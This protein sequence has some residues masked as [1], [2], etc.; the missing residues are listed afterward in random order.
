MANVNIKPDYFGIQTEP[1]TVYFAWT[2]RLPDPTVF[3]EANVSVTNGTLSNF[4][5]IRRIHDLTT[6]QATITPPTTGSGNTV[7]TVAANVYDANEAVT[8]NLP[9]AQTATNT[10]KLY[11][12]PSGD[13]SGP[14]WVFVIIFISPANLRALLSLSNFALISYLPNFTQEDVSIDVGE[15]SDYTGVI[16]PEGSSFGDASVKFKVT[17][18]AGAGNLT[19]TVRANAIGDSPETT[20]TIAYSETDVNV[21]TQEA[22]LPATPPS[23]AID[24]KGIDNSRA[25][26]FTVTNNYFYY[27]AGSFFNGGASLPM[28]R[29]QI[30]RINRAT[31][32]EEVFDISLVSGLFITSRI[33][34][35][36]NI[37]ETIYILTTF[38]ADGAGNAVVRRLAFNTST[39]IA[40]PTTIFTTADFASQENRS[41]ARW[42]GLF[43]DGSQFV[44]HLYDS[45]TTRTASSLGFFIRYTT[46]TSTSPKA[47]TTYGDVDAVAGVLGFAFLNNTLYYRPEYNAFKYTAPN[48]LYVETLPLPGIGTSDGNVGTTF[49]SDNFGGGFTITCLAVH[50]NI[51][52]G[53]DTQNYVYSINTTTGDATRLNFNS[54]IAVVDDVVGLA[55]TNNNVYLPVIKTISNIDHSFL[56]R[57]NRALAF[58]QVKFLSET[59]IR[60]I[61]VFNA[62]PFIIYKQGSTTYLGRWADADATPQVLATISD[63]DRFLLCYNNLLFVTDLNATTFRCY[64]INGTRLSQ[65]DFSLTHRDTLGTVK[66][67]SSNDLGINITHRL[68]NATFISRYNTS[69]LFIDSQAVVTNPLSLLMK[70]T[71]LHNDIFYV[72]NEKPIISGSIF[73]FAIHQVSFADGIQYNGP[74]KITVNNFESFDLKPLFSGETALHEGIG[75]LLDVDYTFVNGVLTLQYVLGQVPIFNVTEIFFPIVAVNATTFLEQEIY[76]SLKENLDLP[77]WNGATSIISEQ[78]DQIDLHEF[79]ENAITINFKSGSTI[80]P[81]VSI[82]NNTL[83]IS[84]NTV[85][86]DS[87]FEIILTAS[88][89][90]GS[91]DKELDLLI[92]NTHTNLKIASFWQKDIIEKVY[93]ADIDV[94]EH[95]ESVSDIDLSLD[96]QFLNVQKVSDATI[97]LNDPDGYFSSASYSNFFAQNGLNRFGFNVPIKIEYG[98]QTANG[99]SSRIIFFGHILRISQN[100]DQAKAT[101]TAIDYNE[102]VLASRL[103]DFGI[104]KKLIYTTSGLLG[105]YH[106]EYLLDPLLLPISNQ[107]LSGRARNFAFLNPK[108]EDSLATEGILNWSN[109]KIDNDKIQSE[110]ELIP[111]APIFSFKTPYKRFDLPDI[112]RSLLLSQE[113]YNYRF[114]IP[115]PTGNADP[116]FQNIGSSV[117]KYEANQK[118]I[119]RDWLGF[120]DD[121]YYLIGSPNISESDKLIKKQE[122]KVITNLFVSNSA[123]SLWKVA[124]EPVRNILWMW[125]SEKY[126]GDNIPLG[127]YDSSEADNKTKMIRY[128]MDNDNLTTQIASDHTNAP[129]L[130]QRYLL[131]RRTETL[132]VRNYA[133]PNNRKYAENWYDETLGDYL[134]YKFANSTHFGIANFDLVNE[135]VTQIIDQ[136]NDTYG[137]AACFDLTLHTDSLFFAYTVGAASSSTLFIKEYNPRTST[138]TDFYQ[139]TTDYT[140]TDFFNEIP[141][142]T[143]GIYNGVLEVFATVDYVY[144]NAQLQKENQLTADTR[145]YDRNGGAILYKIPRTGTT[146]PTTNDGTHYQLKLYEFCQLSPASFVLYDDK[147]HFFEGSPHIYK[148]P[149]IL[150]DGQEANWKDK[151]GFVRYDDDGLK[152]LG[153]AWRD[154]TQSSSDRYENIYGAIDTPI[155]KIGDDL[156]LFLGKST[157]GEQDQNDQIGDFEEIIYSS[158]IHEIIPLLETNNKTVYDLLNLI[159][160]ITYTFSRFENNKLVIESKLVKTAEYV[161]ITGTTLTFKNLQGNL[162]LVGF[163]KIGLELIEY[164]GR[165]DTTLLNI[166]RN[167]FGSVSRIYPEG[168]KLLF[169]DHIIDASAIDNPILSINFSNDYNFLANAISVQYGQNRTNYL[170]DQS[171]IQLNSRKEVNISTLFD[172]HQRIWAENLN[173]IYLD[174]LKDLKQQ[175]NITLDPSFFLR[176]GETII[177]R[178]PERAQINVPCRITRLQ[179]SKTQTVATL[180]S[181]QEEIVTKTGTN[182]VQTNQSGVAFDDDRNRIFIGT[183]WDNETGY[184]NTS[185]NGEIIG[186]F[187]NLNYDP[188]VDWETNMSVSGRKLYLKDATLRHST[189]WSRIAIK[190]LDTEIENNIGTYEYQYFDKTNRN[191]GNHAMVVDDQE[192][193]YVGE[194]LSGE[195]ILRRVVPV[196]NPSSTNLMTIPGDY[197]QIEQR[198]FN[199]T[200]G[201]IVNVITSRALTWYNE[202]IWGHDRDNKLIVE[203]EIENISGSTNRLARVTENV[204]DIPDDV[205]HVADIA[206]GLACWYIVGSDGSQRH[207][208]GRMRDIYWIWTVLD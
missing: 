61:C 79:V 77:I 16:V 160:Q 92:L 157:V 198:R 155:R 50:N 194:D 163:V 148:Y 124:V 75:I 23:E 175:I 28:I 73:Q 167:R 143:G 113:L 107:S 89:S 164:Q 151:S 171:S 80:P 205:T 98:Y 129:Q 174:E 138:T 36:T 118:Y 90:I 193:I 3:T 41:Y 32:E 114:N 15:I 128:E 139:A 176:I 202:S 101:I 172:D 197:I 199:N 21:V 27:V 112:L 52:Y 2:E 51:L 130:A 145:S 53:M 159:N 181:L 206:R 1:Y 109:I 59:A 162:P 64:N 182:L 60:D 95:L 168:E 149:P 14:F 55:Y 58:Q 24:Y 9:Y 108:N 204:V 19:V 140:S 57:F 85:T 117:Y 203:M 8:E 18:P 67:L 146:N 147:A 102:Q 127:T 201:H 188:V 86:A 5:L 37:G 161:G 82:A 120:G 104:D 4:S 66:S 141:E 196:A 133:L 192:N 106:G 34:G 12:T 134:Y 121:F 11:T 165:T 30:N 56:Y 33:L 123:T 49:R 31:G 69:G 39:N 26:W 187:Q 20:L 38:R 13:Q 81:G 63:S 42:N 115:P 54:T 189:A 156:H 208:G 71:D 135:T 195:N 76:F 17:P 166:E 44:M 154:L 40:A 144:V 180:K 125:A 94:T 96:S 116:F 83:S 46:S 68:N 169:F 25:W 132:N 100:T 186:E 178:V 179:H 183:R 6:Y 173:M 48:K 70:G 10:I 87:E 153:I 185:P 45:R 74:S 136:P 142:R 158:T 177:L 105:N 84:T 110:G 103:H 35:L 131:G 29:S 97:S 72:V 22:G 43:Y 91:I 62:D 190:D 111:Y 150:A 93:I 47:G 191:T 200:R 99:I 152:S 126:E 207:V 78:P 88:N 65:N 7:I 184:Y 137:N 170:E 119:M 122:N